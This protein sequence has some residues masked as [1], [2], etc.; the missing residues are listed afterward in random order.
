MLISTGGNSNSF[1]KYRKKAGIDQKYDS[2]GRALIN[3]M[4]LRSWFISKISRLDSNLAKKWAGQKGYMLQYDRM[5][6]EEQLEKYIE[7]EPELLV[8]DN[9]KRETKIEKEYKEKMD[10]MWKFFQN[11]KKD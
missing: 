1:A 7:F 8:Y 4:S 10:L 2:T 6:L 11:M 9:N 3:P 5:T